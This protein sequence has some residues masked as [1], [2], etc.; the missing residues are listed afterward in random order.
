MEMDEKMWMFRIS[1]IVEHDDGTA[2]VNFEFDEEFV[3]WF[4]KSQGLKRWSSARFQKVFSES[5]QNMVNQKHLDEAIKG[6]EAQFED[7]IEL[8]TTY[9]GD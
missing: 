7:E 1:D 6:K 2:T 9:G 8:Y 5:I 3:E 4:K